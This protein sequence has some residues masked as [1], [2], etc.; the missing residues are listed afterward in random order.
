MRASIEIKKRDEKSERDRG[1]RKRGKESVREV[2][3]IGK[4]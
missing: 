1:K 2:R 4:R 3:E